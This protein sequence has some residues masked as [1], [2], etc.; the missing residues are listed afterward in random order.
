M[1]LFEAIGEYTPSVVKSC[2]RCRSRKVKCD[3]KIPQ[4]SA[5]S[6]QG[7]ACNITE[8]VAYPYSLVER[9]H[10]RVQEL[11]QQLAQKG[12]GQS[13][14]QQAASD[15][16]GWSADVTK[17][18]EE[19]GVLAIGFADPYSHSKYVGAA[20]GST[21]ARIFF[22]QV[23]LDVSSAKPAAG[24]YESPDLETPTATIPSRAVAASLLS[25]YIARVHIWWPFLHLPSLRACFQG[26]YQAPRRCSDWHKF[27]FFVVLALAS[28]VAAINTDTP[29]PTLLD[30]NTPPEY[31]QTALHFFA[32]FHDHPRD[33][34]GLQAVVL[35]TIWMLNSPAPKH[36]NDLWQLT[37]YAMSVAL[38]LGIHRHNPAWNF[39]ADDFELRSRL[40]WTIYSLER[41]VALSTGRVLSVRD[42]A[43]DAPTPASRPGSLDRLTAHEADAA[44]LYQAKTVWLFVQMVELRRIAGQVL[45]SIYIARGQDGRCASLTL[46]EIR[47]ISDGLHRRLDRWKGQLDAAGLG[48]GREYKLMKIEYCLLLLHLNRPSPTFMIPSQKMVAICSQASSSAL[49]QWAAMAAADGIHAVC[50]SHCQFH[51]ILMAGLSRLYCDWHIQKLTQNTTPSVRP[52][53]AA[54]CQ[55]LLKKG[56][57]SLGNPSLSKFV[58]LFAVVTSKVYLY[59]PE[60]SLSHPPDFSGFEAQPADSMSLEP[61]GLEAYLH[62]VS[63]IFDNE[64]MDIDDMLT[65]WYGTLLHDANEE[66]AGI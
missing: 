17:E 39:S 66:S 26:M 50:R 11:E 27:I 12:A 53:D 23:G 37:R 46:H 7:E 32:R 3:L 21:F 35:L 40:W 60:M 5:C 30:V 22:K 62:Q 16:L 28:D 19:V 56:V 49:K 61:E 25:V 20:A 65:A 31:L 48:P 57:V 36:G 33:L 14:P 41:S 34:P 51:H 2:N 45:E 13:G 8:Y 58:Q 64:M 54:I 63:D 43:I 24:R 29:S 18:A 42:Q 10:S 38:E 15:S 6:R 52:E 44:P 59:Y 1:P 9:L 4:C 47:S 55:D